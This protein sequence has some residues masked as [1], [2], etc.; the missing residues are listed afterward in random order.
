MRKALLFVFT[1]L[2][3]CGGRTL[4]DWPLSISGGTDGAS[5]GLVALAGAGGVGVAAGGRSGGGGSPSIS[6]AP[7]SGG[8][9]TGGLATGGLATGGFATGGFAM[10]GTATGGTATGGLGGGGR[11]PCFETTQAQEGICIH[12]RLCQVVQYE[13]LCLMDTPTSAVCF[14]Y[15]DGVVTSATSVLSATHD[16]LCEPA[17]RTHCP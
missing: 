14:C 11:E 17:V 13:T 7:S 2:S 10:G 4:G 12:V 8:F 16:K 3:A 15:I 6:G 9:A 1:V 5:G